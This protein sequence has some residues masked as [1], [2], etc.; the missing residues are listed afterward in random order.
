MI[1]ND[2]VDVQEACVLC[3]PRFARRVC[4]PQEFLFADASPR[5]VSILWAAKEA[6]Y[7]ALKKIVPELRFIPS[8]YHCAIDRATCEVEGI[9]VAIQIEECAQFVHAIAVLD[10]SLFSSIHA[11]VIEIDGMPESVAVRHSAATLLNDL[12]Y[13]NCEIKGK[14]PCAYSDRR[15]IDDVDLSLSH[16]GRFAAVSVCLF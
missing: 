6:T 13:P 2:I 4:C 8:L 16:D 1:G 3:H 9:S 12:G 14:P 10:R 5:N 15:K 11:R 7:K